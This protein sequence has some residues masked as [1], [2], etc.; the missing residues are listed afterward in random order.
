MDG[1]KK[2]FGKAA[3]AVSEKVG[4]NADRTEMDPQFKEMERL[5]DCTAKAISE[6]LGHTREYLQPNSSMR[7]HLVS[8]SSYSKVTHGGKQRPEQYEEKLGK[9]MRR[10]GLELEGTNLGTSLLTVSDAMSQLADTK[11]QFDDASKAEF[12]DPLQQMMDKDIKEVAHHRKKLNGRRLDYDY[13]RGKLKSGSKGVT[14]DEVQMSYE[15]LEESIQLAGNSMHTLLSNDVEQV[16]Q[17]Y[18]FIAAMKRYHEES[19]ATLEPILNQLEQQ[20]G[21]IERAPYKEM[22]D[23]SI[24]RDPMVMAMG[25]GAAAATATATRTSAS[26]W[27]STP[28]TQNRP[29]PATR[30]PSAQPRRPTAQA[31]YDFEPENPGELEF[32]EGDVINLTSQIDE[33]W[34]EG[35][36]HGKTGFFPINY[37]KVLVPLN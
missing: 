18:Q 33:N 21:S 16:N 35:E 9:M 37:V 36:I 14:E 26:A 19:A 28:N 5:T 22:A 11:N 1:L 20:K 17:L 8:G 13:K 31:L 24:K 34:F 23:M 32:Q 12:L 30:N 7:T 3:Q 10:T 27:D 15:K 25:G 29:V 4:S 6:L 2:T